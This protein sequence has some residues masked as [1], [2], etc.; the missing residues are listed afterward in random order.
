[1]S[2]ALPGRNAPST[3]LEAPLDMLGTCHGRIEHQCET[4]RRPLAHLPVH[5][6]DAQARNAAS[7]V[8]RRFDSAARDHHEDE[9]QD[10]F[11]AVPESMA[12]SDATCLREMTQS[13]C[14][15]HR[16]LERHWH[17]VRAMLESVSSGEASGF[18]AAAVEALIEAYVRHIAREDG[19]RL[20][21][22][23]RLLDDDALRDIVRAM[24]RH[25]GI[26]QL[27]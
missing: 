1:M 16:L 19:E 21:M 8:M 12:G 14:A 11:P 3:G 6:A 27:P 10:L 2:P 22:A 7:A 23:A 15:E 18:D 5:G 26:R 25:R 20:P 24:R 13:L 4:L 9:E 17:T